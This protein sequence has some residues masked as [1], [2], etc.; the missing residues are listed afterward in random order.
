MLELATNSNLQL[1]ETDSVCLRVALDTYKVD[2][3]MTQ[4]IDIA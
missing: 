2:D 1:V 4:Y 3:D